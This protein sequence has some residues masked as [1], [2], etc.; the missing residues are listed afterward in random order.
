[1]SQA[2]WEGSL[3]SVISVNKADRGEINR[4]PKRPKRLSCSQLHGNNMLMRSNGRSH[5]VSLGCVPDNMTGRG[6]KA[7]SRGHFGQKTRKKVE[8]GQADGLPSITCRL[9]W[10]GQW[11]RYCSGFD[12]SRLRASRPRQCQSQEDGFVSMYVDC[13][14]Y[15]LIPLFCI[16]FT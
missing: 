7:R 14:T 8:K 9:R 13:F 1:M 4:F 6:S 10:L 16:S 5:L 12:A 11:L 3:T 2:F 15:L